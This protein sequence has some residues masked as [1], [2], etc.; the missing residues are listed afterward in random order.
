MKR[1][2]SMKT[3]VIGIWLI[4]AMALAMPSSVHAIGLE[5]A[6]GGWN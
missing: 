2:K 1:E 3:A 5:V 6:I 4:L